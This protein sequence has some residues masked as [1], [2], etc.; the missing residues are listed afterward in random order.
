MSREDWLIA[1][2]GEIRPWFEREGY[3]LSRFRIAIGFPGTGKRG[4][5]IGECWDGAC[6]ADGTFEILIRPD[7]D[8]PVTVAGV[9]IHEL[10]HV[11]VGL[12]VGHK[13]AFAKL[14]RRLGLVGPMTATTVGDELRCDL[15]PMLATLGPLPHARLSLGNSSGPKKQTARLLKAVC[16]ECGYVVRV[17]RKWVVEI[18]A[19]H[20]PKHGTMDVDL[21]DADD[22]DD[23]QIDIDEVLSRGV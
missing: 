14:A 12:A 23:A 19:P 7:Q 8:D 9:L 22:I 5:R 17:A 6:S 11:A 10:I 1:L 4:N 18:G 15:V 2:A 13:G 20:C 21:G 16:P 3:D